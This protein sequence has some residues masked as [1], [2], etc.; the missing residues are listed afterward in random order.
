MLRLASPFVHN[1]RMV[2]WSDEIHAVFLQLNGYM[3]RPDLDSAFLARAGVKLDRA[4]FPLL[5][6]IGLSA[7]IGVVDL[8]GLVGRNHSTVSRQADK[9]ESLGLVERHA[10]TS[11]QRVRLLRPS[12]AGQKMLAQFAE[13]RRKF[14]DER[15]GDWATD[16]RVLLLDLLK[17]FSASMA[18]FGASEDADYL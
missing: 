8:A 13:T 11:D 1:A 10:V 3:N 9:L 7:P 6:R 18:G 12:A 14:L 15:L 5:T 16:E 4:L 17:K 2:D